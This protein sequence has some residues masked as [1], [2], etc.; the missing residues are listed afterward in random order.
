MNW[1]ESNVD[2]EYEPLPEITEDNINEVKV[3]NPITE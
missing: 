2:V 3:C 1:E